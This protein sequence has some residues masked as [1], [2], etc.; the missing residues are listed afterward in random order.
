VVPCAEIVG[1]A[2]ETVGVLAAPI[3]QTLD[4]TTDLMYYGARYYDPTSGRFISADTIVPGGG[5]VPQGLNRYSYA[6]NNPIRYNDPTG[7]NPAA[8]CLVPGVNAVC[9]AVATAAVDYAVAAGTGILTGIGVAWWMNSDDGAD[10]PARSSGLDHLQERL[11]DRVN[12]LPAYD[13]PDISILDMPIGDIEINWSP[14]PLDTV[15]PLPP[16]SMPALDS[17]DLLLRLV[18]AETVWDY[19]DLIDDSHLDAAKRELEGEVVAVRPD[20]T[21]FDHVGEVRDLMR[22]LQNRL[23]AI[24]KTLGHPPLPDAD[25]SALTNELSQG[26]RFLDAVENLLGR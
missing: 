1:D 25:R 11:A 10:T 17:T 23:E 26:S 15:E 3:G 6:I 18:A 21:P 12:D 13:G 5:A 2:D 22:G 20:G 14:I 8:V 24:L 16:M 19:M 7:H 4:P 9:A